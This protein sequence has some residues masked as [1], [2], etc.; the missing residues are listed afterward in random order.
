M[1]ASHPGAA[2]PTSP[3]P[4]PAIAW[5]GYG[6]ALPFVAL[7]AVSWL[8]PAW[9]PLA[10]QALLGYGAVILSFVG[11]LHWGVAMMAP[12]HALSD[13]AR[14]QAFVWSVV[15]A[16]LAWAA[17]LLPSAVAPWVAMTGFIT[18]YLQDL[19]LS[20]KTP[21]PYWYLRL[22]RHLSGLACLGLAAG[23]ISQ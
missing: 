10:H 22:R 14:T 19:R 16:L 18:H 13:A 4:P 2:A 23:S 1:N 8:M 9:R 17:L 11:A 15:P 6:G 12:A 3:T 20:R 5:L 7:A 21:L